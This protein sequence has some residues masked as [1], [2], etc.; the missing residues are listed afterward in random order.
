MSRM[1]DERRAFLQLAAAAAVGAAVLPPSVAKALALPAHRVTGT[2]KDV[3]HV[4]ILMQ[5]NRSF[6]HYFGSLRG[7]RG[8]DDPT[9]RRPDGGSLFRQA[10]AGHAD[11]YVAP[12]RMN[13][14]HTSGQRVENL[15]HA[16]T[17][18]HAAW[19]GGAMDR[20][21]PAH[22]AADGDRG[23]LTMGHFTREDIPYYYALA[24]AFTLCD[25]YHCSVFGPTRTAIS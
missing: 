1:S 14:R 13:T 23:P 21:V 25:G 22:R 16:W 15:S 19:N 5:E 12:F 2:I 6:D 17:V 3:E 8:F 18:Q 11:G 10:D 7:V 9:A 4:V 20:W 24:D